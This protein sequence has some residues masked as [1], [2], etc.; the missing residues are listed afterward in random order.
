MRDEH[1]GFPSG[2][3]PH[4]NA[5][6]FGSPPVEISD[7]F[8]PHADEAAEKLFLR[9]FRK[10]RTRRNAL[11][12]I[13]GP[14]LMILHTPKARHQDPPRSFSATSDA[15]RFGR[16]ITDQPLPAVAALKGDP[17]LPHH[18]FPGKRSSPEESTERTVNEASSV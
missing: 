16:R 13:G 15:W 4:A 11:C 2:E 14:R 17:A 9:E 8:S 3:K 18:F 7:S 5:W 1:A 10:K 12:A 6:R